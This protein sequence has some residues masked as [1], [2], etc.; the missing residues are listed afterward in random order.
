MIAHRRW[1]WLVSL[2][3][4]LNPAVRALADEPA[5]DPAARQLVDDIAKAY[6]KLPGY[7]DHGSVT[8]DMTID[9]RPFQQVLPFSLTFARPNKLAIDSGTSA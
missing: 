8:L 3:L 6:H 9:G 4:Y 1:Y 5:I 2:A 7:A